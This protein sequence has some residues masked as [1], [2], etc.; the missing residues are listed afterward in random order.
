MSFVVGLTGGIGSGKSTV[1]SCFSQYGATIIDADDI[2]RK[3]IDVDEAALAELQQ[4]FGMDIVDSEGH[5]IRACLAER[6]FASRKGTGVLNSIM[7]P[8]IRKQAIADMAALPQESITVYDMPLLVETKSEDLC[9]VVVVVNSPIEERVRRLQKTR[10]MSV[11]EISQ[12]IAQ[13]ASDSDRNEVADIV[14]DNN[15]TL[16]NLTNECESAWAT[17]LEVAHNSQRRTLG[18]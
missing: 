9:D 6:A 5:L 18:P 7:H 15:G 2:A 8:R 1:A 17:I 13:Q 14:I 11:E 10:G 3:V 12:R 4:A 16:E